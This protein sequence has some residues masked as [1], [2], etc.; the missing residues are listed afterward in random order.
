MSEPQMLYMILDLEAPVEARHSPAPPLN[1]CLVLDRST[2]MQG[3]K[4]DLVKAAAVQV[5]RNLR[6]Q[7]VLSVVTFSDRAEVVIPASLFQERSRLE[8][9]IQMIHP[10]GATEIYQGLETGVKEV[11][12]S[13]DSRRVNHIVLLTDG[14]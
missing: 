11:M 8:A 2:S 1:V 4:M 6:P 7:D 9:K 12:H 5:L 3:E 13:L 14:H 10:S